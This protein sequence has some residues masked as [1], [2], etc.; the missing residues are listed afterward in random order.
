MYI[1]N[2][3]YI[4]YNLYQL[5][6]FSMIS[7]KKR[8]EKKAVANQLVSIDKYYAMIVD[9]L[10]WFYC[11]YRLFTNDHD[12]QIGHNKSIIF[13]LGLYNSFK[14]NGKLYWSISI[15]D[16]INMIIYLTKTFDFNF[17][18]NWF[19]HYLIFYF[20]TWLIVLFYF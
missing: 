19:C 7:W 10:L 15:I 16:I 20:F 6:F 2:M 5:L 14:R 11:G 3:L 8:K 4:L 18:L 13:I 9:I 17:S 12:C 1:S